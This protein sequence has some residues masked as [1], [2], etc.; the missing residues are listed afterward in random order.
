MSTKFH[1]KFQSDPQGL[2]T[3]ETTFELR[4]RSSKFKD[5]REELKSGT[6]VSNNVKL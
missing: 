4:N 3:S 2:T 6:F 1:L 5:K